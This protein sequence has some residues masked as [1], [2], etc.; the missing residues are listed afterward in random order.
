VDARCG[1]LRSRRFGPHVHVGD[2]A[3]RKFPATAASTPIVNLAGAP[4][5]GLPWTDAR[6]QLLI[7]SRVKTTQAVL[8]WTCDAQARFPASS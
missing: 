3:R 8:D 1:T 6:R 7:D 2:E 5:I 4:V